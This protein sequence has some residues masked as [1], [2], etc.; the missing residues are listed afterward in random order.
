MN[1]ELNGQLCQFCNKNPARNEKY[2]GVL[3]ICQKCARLKMINE[4]S[5]PPTTESEPPPIKTKK[6]KECMCNNEA[7]EMGSW[8]GNDYCEKCFYECERG[9]EQKRGEVAVNR[10]L[11]LNDS[12]TMSEN[13]NA[14]GEC[15]YGR[16]ESR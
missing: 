1:Q 12:G 2:C 6:C 8:A 5:Q 14:Y 11:G 13:R 7:V 3:Y 9:A 16:S 4:E 10:G 15:D